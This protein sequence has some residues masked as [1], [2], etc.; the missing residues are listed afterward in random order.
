VVRVRFWTW[1]VRD[2]TAVPCLVDFGCG[3]QLDFE[4]LSALYKSGFSYEEFACRNRG[5]YSKVNARANNEALLT[6]VA[7]VVNGN[8]VTRLHT[9]SIVNT[10][11]VSWK[12]NNAL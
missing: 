2:I 1:F 4:D 12:A 11:S 7:V 3:F 10:W 9:K 8:D 6:T 5:A